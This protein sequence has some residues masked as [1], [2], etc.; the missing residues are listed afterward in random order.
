MTGTGFPESGIPLK[1][2]AICCDCDLGF[3]ASDGICPS[4][5]TTV[6]W[7]LLPTKFTKLAEKDEPRTGQDPGLAK[8]DESDAVQNPRMVPP[9]TQPSR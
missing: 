7:M 5:G 9:E 4:C 3:K 1:D 6:G 2:L 8:G